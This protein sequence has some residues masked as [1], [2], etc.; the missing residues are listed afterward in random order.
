MKRIRI[1]MAC[2]LIVLI[3]S[4]YSITT[5]KAYDDDVYKIQRILQDLGYNIGS[6]DGLLGEKTK[7][8]IKKFQTDN[9][10]K[11]T[12]NIDQDTKDALYIKE[13]TKKTSDKPV[14]VITTSSTITTIS[15]IESSISF[16]LNKKFTTHELSS[17]GHDIIISHIL[18]LMKEKL[19]VSDIVSK[20][21]NEIGKDIIQEYLVEKLD[22]SGRDSEE[23]TEAV[24][25]SLGYWI[26]AN[27]YHFPCD[28]KIV[29][30]S[31]ESLVKAFGNNYQ[32][33]KVREQAGTSLIMIGYCSKFQLM[34]AIRN[35]D[36]NNRIM[37]AVLLTKLDKSFETVRYFID[38]LDDSSIDEEAVQSSAIGLVN[39]G[40]SA[41]G[42]L[43]NKIDNPW[44]SHDEKTRILAANIL[45]NICKMNI[46][47]CITEIEKYHLHDN[48]M[49][50]LIQISEILG[51]DAI[52]ILE[53]V[54]RETYQDS[55][56]SKRAIIALRKI[57]GS[58]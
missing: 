14:E 38:R 29:E 17:I 25:L 24:A 50:F 11:V 55:E 12:G 58:Q 10:L 1:I 4:S 54:M 27:Y 3:F 31:I 44:A 35:K 6:P 42:H 5:A 43:L 40:I 9:R 57:K 49:Y 46:E 39:I 28:H 18:E 33:K 37:M 45:L 23:S 34:N 36:M 52:P 30:N 22:Y 26:K 13:I 48:S 8:A 15:P 2:L 16:W 53:Y 56:I 7:T 32:G 41:I 21:L 20:A 19:N 47:S 51:R